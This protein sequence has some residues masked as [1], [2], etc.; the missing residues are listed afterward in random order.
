MQ[1]TK[2]SPKRQITIPKEICKKLNLETG[3]YLEVDTINE[4]IV[5]IPKKLISRDQEWFWSKEWQAKEKEA[6]EA[7]SR[8]EVSQIFENADDL[9][10]HLRQQK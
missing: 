6:D 10:K 4:G 7:I 5:L 3:D 1:I 2:I 9:I 8:C